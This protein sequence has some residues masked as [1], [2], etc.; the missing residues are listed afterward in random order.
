M[1]TEGVPLN[2]HSFRLAVSVAVQVGTRMLT[3]A[4]GG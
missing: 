2:G 3:D 1:L 4:D